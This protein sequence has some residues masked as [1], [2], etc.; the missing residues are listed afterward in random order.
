[1]MHLSGYSYVTAAQHSS[2]LDGVVPL[3]YPTHVLPQW[4]GAKYG[5]FILG[6]YFRRH[7]PA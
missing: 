1:M 7:A 6:G 2:W 4:L 5:V 3:N